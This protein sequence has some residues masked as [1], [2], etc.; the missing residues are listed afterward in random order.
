MTYDAL[1]N[2]TDSS[3]SYGA[4]NRIQAWGGCSYSTDADGNVTQRVCS[5]ATVNFY[6]SADGHLDSLSNAGSMTAFTYDPSGP[7]GSP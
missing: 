6:W 3:G 7:D 1:G 4:G 2:R 5:G